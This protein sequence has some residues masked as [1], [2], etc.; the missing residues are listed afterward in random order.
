MNISELSIAELI[1]NNEKDVKELSK[2]IIRH[3]ILKGQ[4]NANNNIYTILDNSFV[5]CII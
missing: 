3:Y 4:D 1:K 2:D 5:T